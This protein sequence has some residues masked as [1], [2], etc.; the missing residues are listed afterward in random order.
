MLLPH[1]A[2][3]VEHGIS[4]SMN[5]ETYAFHKSKETQVFLAT[6]GTGPL[7]ETR[8]RSR[9]DVYRALHSDSWSCQM[10]PATG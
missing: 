7:R 6:H 8:R 3:D 9:L 10:E 1:P 5:G 4:K 2:I